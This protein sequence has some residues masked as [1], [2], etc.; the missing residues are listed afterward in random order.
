MK[1]IIREKID[2]GLYLKA[3]GF[4]PENTTTIL[5]TIQEA[6]DNGESFLDVDMLDM[7]ARREPGSEE[8]ELKAAVEEAEKALRWKIVI[9]GSIGRI[10]R[11]DAVSLC[12][13]LEE[14]DAVLT[15]C[16]EQLTAR[17]IADLWNKHHPGE[18]IFTAPSFEL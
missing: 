7:F 13:T 8:Q 11:A 15:L 6:W 17:E 1:N 4:D 10:Q 18:E 3:M 16:G 14:M 12:N 5:D 9:P 2:I